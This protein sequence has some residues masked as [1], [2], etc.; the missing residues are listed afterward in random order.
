[1]PHAVELSNQPSPLI[2]DERRSLGFAIGKEVDPGTN[3]TREK[4]LVIHDLSE[5]SDNVVARFPQEEEPANPLAFEGDDVFRFAIDEEGGRLIA[6]GSIGLNTQP[7]D[8]AEGTD[9]TTYDYEPT[10][11]GWAISEQVVK[12]PCAGTQR[13]LAVSATVYEAGQGDDKVRKLLVAGSYAT[14]G[15]RFGGLALLGFGNNLGQPLVV[16]QL[17]LDALY[18]SVDEVDP[19]ALDWEIDLRYVGCGRWEGRT[20]LLERIGPDLISYC[21]DIQPLVRSLGAQGYVVRI[22]LGDDHLPA[23]RKGAPVVPNPYTSGASVPEPSGAPD[24]NDAPGVDLGLIAT[25]CF[26]AGGGL[27]TAPGFDHVACAEAAAGEAERQGQENVAWVFEE[28]AE[29]VPGLPEPPDPDDPPEPPDPDDPPAV[30]SVDPENP[31]GSKFIANPEVRRTPTLP[32][33][34]FPFADPASGRILLLT[35]NDV[36]GNAVWVFD[37]VAERFVGLVTGGFVGQAIDK[38]AGAFDRVRGRA[39]VFTSEG[40]LSASARQTPL[41][42]GRVD[43]VADGDDEV[44]QWR[45]MAVAPELRRLYITL[46]KR[47]G[48]EGYLVMQDDVPDPPVPSQADPDAITT[49][50]D[51][52]PGKTDVDRSGAAIASGAHVVV[53]GGIPRTI[54][55]LDPFCTAPNSLLS[56]AAFEREAFDGQ[57]LADQVVTRGSRE[58]MLAHSTGE[59]GTATGA[60][61][62]ASG[63]FFPLTERPTDSDIKNLGKC[64]QTTAQGFSEQFEYSQLCNPL[65]DGLT[66]VLGDDLRNGTRGGTDGEEGKGFPVPSAECSD[67]GGGGTSDQA[68][69]GVKS[70]LVWAVTDCDS[71]NVTVAGDAASTG[72]ALPTVA[73]PVVSV[74]RFSSDVDVFPGEAGQ[75]TKATATAA[76]VAVGPLSVAEI[77]TTA[78]VTTR[79][80][81]GTAAAEFSRQWCGVVVDGADLGDKCRDPRTDPELSEAIDTLNQSFGRFRITVPE[82]QMQ[83]TPG[84]AQAVVTKDPGV[85]AA[86]QAVNGDDSLTVPGIQVAVFNDGEEGRNR[87]VAQ[88][89]GIHVE[90]RY[91]IVL[92][93]DFDVP[94]FPE[95]QLPAS[96]GD[97]FVPPTVAGTQARTIEDPVRIITIGNEPP[98]NP[99][100]QFF[101]APAQALQQFLSWLINN[102]L[103]AALLFMLLSLLA[104]PIYLTLRA[105]AAARALELSEM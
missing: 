69:G 55:Q 64:G 5:M 57:C 7:C 3:G 2:V 26:D 21:W 19:D 102:P 59:T 76:G 74:A 1:M 103:E 39:Y 42:G 60:V 63:L 13:F 35:A 104:S 90:S 65:Q 92:L 29:V 78:T 45:L 54:N 99:M 48:K 43:A 70:A 30:P 10:S 20:V 9:V 12:M 84:G 22:P 95:V 15:W 105:R 23:T 27:P 66:N 97:F 71:S 73:D 56:D 77:R 83:A 31:A 96:V 17:D 41:P 93:P 32:G 89:A 44:T 33:E 52:E 79:G 72:L 34:V 38:S 62:E 46:Q 4:R 82:A 50:V 94:D 61:A 18:A 53:A 25:A 87:Y 100:A 51:E 68:P 28:L 98:D 36:N 86:D 81:T 80:R 47:P 101:N 75:V 88:F 24:P 67:F 6:P 85:R 40:I 14:E 49:Q 11:S 58:F 16:R 8:P 91:G 37:P